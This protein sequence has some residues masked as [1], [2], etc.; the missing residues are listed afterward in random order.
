VKLARGFRAGAAQVDDWGRYPCHMDRVSS[1]N[2]ES[3]C[4]VSP[5]A[6]KPAAP[7]GT[8]PRH[9]HDRGNRY[10]CS[11]PRPELPVVITGAM[12]TSGDPAGTAWPILPMPFGSPRS[13]QQEPR[14]DGRLC[15]PGIRG[16]PGRK[17]STSDLDAFGAACCGI[18]D[19]LRGWGSFSAPAASRRSL[20]PDFRPR[21][22]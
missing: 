16:A 22:Q 19:R 8:S 11:D 6:P 1:G 17:D 10:P 2:C 14:R 7:S 3:M 13:W 21:S 5:Q 20:H 15:R 12:R 9:R 4:A 18:G